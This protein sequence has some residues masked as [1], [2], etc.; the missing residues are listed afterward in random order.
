VVD[1]AILVATSVEDASGDSWVGRGEVRGDVGEG[2]GAR[3]EAVGLEHGEG[4]GAPSQHAVNGVSKEL[5][6]RGK[7]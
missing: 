2:V 5:A 6:R 4:Y 7:N 3:H 1:G